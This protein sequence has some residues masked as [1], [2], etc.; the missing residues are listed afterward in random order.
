M[1]GVDFTLH[2]ILTDHIN[3]YSFPRN[4]FDGKFGDFSMEQ[5]KVSTFC[6]FSDLLSPESGDQSLLK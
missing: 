2:I 5:N 6:P 3:P 1:D 4:T